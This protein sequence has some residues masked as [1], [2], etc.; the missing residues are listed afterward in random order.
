MPAGM[1]WR[2][3]R[4]LRSRSKPPGFIP[5]CQP[6]LA[7]RPPAGPGWLHEIKFD[8]YRVIARKDGGQVRLWARTTS[9]YSRAFTRIRDA[10]AALPSIAPC[11]TARR[12]FCAR[13]LLRLRGAKIAAGPSRGDSRRKHY[14]SGDYPEALIAAKDMIG[15]HRLRAGERLD[16]RGRYLGIG[17]AS[18][19]EQ[20]AHGTEV[21]AAWGLPFVPG[22][23]Q[24]HVKLTPDGAL[25]IK[26]GINTIGQGLETT[27]A[28]IAHEMTGVPFYDIRVTL[29]D[30]A[31]TPFSTGAYAS[32]GIVMSGGAV[33]RASSVVAERI[34]RIAAHLMQV[35]AD[36]IT[37]LN[38]R[39]YAGQASLSYADIG[40]AWYLRPEQLPEAVNTG[41]LKR[42]R[43]I[44]RA[45]IQ[46]F[47]R[48][49]PMLQSLR[50]TQ[51]QGSSRS[52]ITLSLKIAG[53]W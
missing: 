30:T 7:A 29:G 36:A 1:L 21:F 11:S 44:N 46:G 45:S 33:S 41:G 2:V 4:P 43:P 39:I 27:L 10:V 18:Y 47:F 42:Q 15:L 23:D 53:K 14:D 32:R 20:S 5:P 22:F 28:Q 50:L 12:S 40:N 26:A 16:A 13:Q 6:A 25:E 34:K 48:T 17:F 37:F 24:A 19:T 31:T 8:E 51:K 3:S 9:D 52:S 49:Q 35:R 38:G